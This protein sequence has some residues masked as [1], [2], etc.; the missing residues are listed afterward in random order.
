MHSTK[1]VGPSMDPR[2]T[3]ALTGFSC[4]DRTT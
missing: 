2:E 3:P 4:D 1:S